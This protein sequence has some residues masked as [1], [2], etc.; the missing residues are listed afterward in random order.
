MNN[1]SSIQPIIENVE[2]IFNLYR[3]YGSADYIGENVSQ[4][5]HALQCA[6]QAAKEY[7]NNNGYIL[8]ALFHDIGHLIA[9]DNGKTTQFDFSNISMEGLGLAQHENIGADFLEYMGF[10]NEVSDLGRYHVLAKRYLITKDP[11]YHQNLSG[12]SKKTF[13]K[14]GGVLSNIE[15]EQLR[16]KP[17]LHVYINMRIWDDR[18]KIVDFDY[19]HNLDYYENMAVN[20]L[21]YNFIP[22]ST[23]LNS[24]YKSNSN[25]K[26]VQSI[27]H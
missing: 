20:Y 16:R 24:K 27:L 23:P 13:I 25:S 17:R 19:D 2:L 3:A 11:S 22:I 1:Y 12:A 18:A 14:Q 9:L 10:P 5:E 8:G 15:M 7:P 4:L 26:S 6:E 21:T